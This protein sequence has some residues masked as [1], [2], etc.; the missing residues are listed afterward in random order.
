M[1][2]I[3]TDVESGDPRLAF[4]H[5]GQAR[6][7]FDHRRLAS[8]VR[9]EQ[10]ED[11]P[12]GDLHIDMVNGRQFAVDFREI[13]RD[14]RITRHAPPQSLR[15]DPHCFL[16]H[17]DHNLAEFVRLLRRHLAHVRAEELPRG[18]ELSEQRGSLGTDRG[19]EGAEALLDLLAA[20]PEIRLALPGDP[21]RLETIPAY[22]REV[23]SA[24]D[25]PQIR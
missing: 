7:Q 10:T 11:G 21:I 24:E 25:G 1:H 6:E 5:V 15:K 20:A 23:Y 16:S 13:F 19:L 9:A 12:R 8:A 14:D 3:P 18:P 4:R 2:R 22:H 17:L